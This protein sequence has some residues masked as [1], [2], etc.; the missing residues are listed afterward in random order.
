MKIDDFLIE[1]V[2]DIMA[3][4]NDVYL[5]TNDKDLRRICVKE[6]IKNIFMR[7]RKIL[8]VQ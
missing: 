2:K 6:G 1:I 3:Q 4:K 8:C 5:A 7:Q